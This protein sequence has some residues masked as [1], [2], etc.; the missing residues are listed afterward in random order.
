MKPTIE[1]TKNGPLLVKSLA[2][3]LDCAGF[4]IK[5]TAC[6]RDEFF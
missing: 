6:E 2:K 5:N 1:C 4:D 3:P